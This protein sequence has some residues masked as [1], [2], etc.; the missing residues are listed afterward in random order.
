MSVD[1]VLLHAPS[2]Y[3]FRQKTILYGP[4]SDLIPPSPAFE[5]YPIGFASLAEYLE[6]V[7]YRVRIVNL[8][9]RMLR[10]K[11]FDA[12]TFIKQLR[13]PVFGIDLHWMVHCHGAIEIARLVKKHHPES[14]VLFGGFSASYFY[15]ELL[16][17]PE[18]DYVLRGDSTE[19]PLRQLMDC[20]LKGK[21]PDA[22]PNLAW[23][24][25]QGSIRESPFSYIPAD[26]GNVMGNH[27]GT[28]VRSVLRYRDLASYIPFK[29]WL[30]YPITAVITCRGCTENC[31]ICGG[32]AAAFRK[33]Y[34]RSQPVFRS[35]EAVAQDVKNIGRFSRGPIFI[36]GDLRQPGE[37]YPCDVLRL[38]QQDG[39]NNQLI[40]ELFSPAPRELLQRMSLACS[41]FCLEISPESHDPEVRRA[42]G[43]HFTTEALEQTISDALEVGCGRVDVFFMV[44][45]PRQTPHSVMETIDYC[46]YLLDRF[47]GDKRLCLFI[48][49]LSPFLDPGS[50]GF[51]QPERYGYRI[52]FRTLEEHRQALVAPSWQYSLNYETEWLTRQQIAEVAY[53]AILR[54]NRLK[55]KYGVIPKQ[56][57]E[58]GEQRILAARD[59]MHRMDE[60]LAQGNPEQGLP[61]LKPA[62]DRINAYPVGEKIQLELPL[63][64]IKLKFWRAPWYL[65]AGGR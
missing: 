62:V 49:P 11:K 1:L 25:G 52:L 60:I 50:L 13:A 63:G 29:D 37:S 27:Y 64:L 51:E 47:R 24:D 21:E 9:V 53:E 17:Y 3:D 35:P 42:S 30:R 22:V 19:E 7:G 16:K 57:A 32:S 5:L 58:V 46:G 56:M 2:V 12:E 4:V 45:L 8:A 31:V 23:R 40:F 15:K 26:L 33:S 61:R 18:V 43:R 28:I 20:L 6:R 10:D 55:A 48:A 54:L 65:R 38:L 59:I 14:K 34:N 41:D 44:G 36:L 39:V